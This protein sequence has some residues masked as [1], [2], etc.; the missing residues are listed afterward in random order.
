MRAIASQDLLVR[1]PNNR[2]HRLPVDEKFVVIQASSSA[3][4]HG[5]W[6]VYSEPPRRRMA[7]VYRA[8]RMEGVAGALVFSVDM[9]D[10]GEE[11]AVIL[12]DRGVTVLCIQLSPPK[13]P[14][15]VYHEYLQ[16]YCRILGVPGPGERSV[17]GDEAEDGRLPRPEEF[18]FRFIG[19]AL[20]VVSCAR[21]IRPDVSKHE[22]G[23]G[24][25]TGVD[26]R[27]T[28]EAWKSRP[29]W[30]SASCPPDGMETLRVGS[31]AVRALRAVPRTSCG[32]NMFTG[33]ASL[34]LHS[35]ANR[36]AHGAVGGMAA[37][38][39][40]GAAKRVRAL[41]C[42]TPLTLSEAW[43]YIECGPF[44]PRSQELAASLLEF[45]RSLLEISKHVPSPCG[46]APFLL[47]PPELIFQA[48]VTAKCLLALGLSRQH[49]SKGIRAAHTA[50]GCRFG[51]MVAWA[52]TS[53]HRLQG[54][55]DS[56]AKPSG[57]EPDMVVIDTQLNRTL[58]LDAKFRR[59]E[60]GLLPA[61][62]I[63]DMQAY[64]HEYELPTAVVAV[65]YAPGDGSSEDVSA[66]GFTVRGLAF[67]P[68]IGDGDI[69]QVSSELAN[70]W[71]D[72]LVTTRLPSD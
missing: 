1:A 25:E 29:E 64:M 66:K 57:Y 54:W 48:F 17:A 14:I 69:A 18:A 23:R 3:H 20:G 43:N 50:A 53:D 67:S 42:P 2:V 6:L 5:Q 55:R 40:E 35:L 4:V 26:A 30:Y 51:N 70:S 10:T 15:G 11:F 38:L 24:G 71:N 58:L 60:T 47:S 65:P 32:T 41:D 16:S 8:T 36:V 63:K 62:G 39:L 72:K 21:L 33:A 12:H 34:A 46:K 56:T 9:T 22:R 19:R 68:D 59:D 28:L 44:P 52:D 13:C 31:F 49:L 7:G 61:S 45:R 37:V 27:K